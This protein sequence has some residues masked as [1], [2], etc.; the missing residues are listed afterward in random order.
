MALF[1]RAG[2]VV[3]EQHIESDA[4]LGPFLEAP[5]ASERETDRAVHTRLQHMYAAGAWVLWFVAYGKAHFEVGDFACNGFDEHSPGHYAMEQ[6]FLAEALLTMFFLI[7]IMGATSKRAPAGF[8]GLA[9]GLGLTLIHLVSIPV[10]NTSVNPAR[11]TGTALVLLGTNQRWAS[12]NLALL[13][14]SD[15]RR[16]CRRFLLSDYG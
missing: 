3:A 10:T 14:R 2:A 9:I 4:D 11:S 16:V 8:A 12:N 15:V 7:I 1:A 6:C 13:G 5:P